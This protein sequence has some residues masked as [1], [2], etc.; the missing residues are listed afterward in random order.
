[1]LDPLHFSEDLIR[2]D[3]RSFVSNVAAAERVREELRG[4]DVEVIDYA[5]PK[6]VSKRNLVAYR[7]PGPGGLLLSGHLDTVPDTGWTRSAF[8]PL[9][10]GGR[11]TGLGSA[12]MKG[13]I[14]AMV[15]AGASAPEN[16]PVTFL[17]T[18]DE[19][20]GKQGV[21]EVLK[22]SEL[23]RRHKPRAIVIGEPTGLTCLRGHRVDIQFTA[24]A[25]GVQAHSSTGEG[26][27]AN[28][29]LIPF[30]ADMR[31]L[32]YTLRRD[33]R[34]H[35]PLYTPPFCDLNLVV[36]NYGAASNMTVGKATCRIKFRYSKSFDPEWVVETIQAA[37]R[38]NGLALSVAREASPPELAPEHPLVQLGVR[39]SGQ[40]AR[41]AGLG[42]EASELKALAPTIVI[43]PGRIE[44]AHRPGEHID[45][46][47]L[48]QSVEL[49]AKFLEAGKGLPLS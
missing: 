15:A 32:H 28:L 36:D 10:E 30:L 17:F 46:A 31:E 44:D 4:F 23:L 20:A 1:M 37:A 2:L 5:D 41:V 48:R 14:A 43:G 33:T 13:P 22:R 9:V 34:Y 40:P 49:F 39:L 26:V 19:E 38:R 12:Y 24:D 11:L 3:S 29:A 21:R 47:Q 35:D 42:T 7:G 6:G 8:E 18:A 16:L 27:N 25:E 45:V